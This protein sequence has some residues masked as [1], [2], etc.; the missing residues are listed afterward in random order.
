M[1][2]NV[3]FSEGNSFGR[4]E[5]FYGTAH[6]YGVNKGGVLLKKFI[7]SLFVRITGFPGKEA[8]KRLFS[9]SMGCY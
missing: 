2:K 4:H 5:W 6:G 7:N 1:C 8:G 3:S 9:L